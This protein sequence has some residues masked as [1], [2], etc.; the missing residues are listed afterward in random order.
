VD[1]RDTE[2]VRAHAMVQEVDDGAP[3]ARAVVAV[4]D[5]DDELRRLIA[6][7]G[8][9]QRPLEAEGRPERRRGGLVPAPAGREPGHEQRSQKEQA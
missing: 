6:Q 5:R 2:R 4:D 3:H 8:A 7:R 9:R 1:L